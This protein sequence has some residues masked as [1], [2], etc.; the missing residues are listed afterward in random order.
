MAARSGGRVT[1]SASDY[2]DQ[3]QSSLTGRQ[4]VFVNRTVT[5]HVIVHD[6]N[7]RGGG[8]GGGSSHISSGGGMHGGGGR[9]F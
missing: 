2:T 3:N 7:S 1:D 5:H 4:D 8:G 9:S 6:D